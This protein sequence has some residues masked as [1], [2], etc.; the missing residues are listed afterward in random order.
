METREKAIIYLSQFYWYEN[1]TKEQQQR[2]ISTYVIA[3]LEG[4]VNQLK[5]QLKS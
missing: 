4:E 2:V 1:L 3:F 5:K